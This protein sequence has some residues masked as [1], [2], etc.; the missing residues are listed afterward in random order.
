MLPQ[1]GGTLSES[2]H[3][4]D[5]VHHEVEA[6]EIVQHGHVERRG[7]RALFLVAAHVQV[8]VV[9]AGGRS[10]GESATG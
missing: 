4:V 2:R 1:R 9:G 6:V 3:A 10:G 8:V 5:D 7:G